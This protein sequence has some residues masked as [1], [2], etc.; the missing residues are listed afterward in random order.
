MALGEKLRKA[1]EERGMS[2][3]DVAASTH[4]L[5]RQIEAIEKEDFSGI[6]APIYGKGFVKLFAECVGL[7]PAPL[8]AEFLEIY[9]GARPPVIARRTIPQT[10]PMRRP[11]ARPVHRATAPAPVA[12]APAAQPPAA[13][14]APVA[15]TPV[16]PP[17]APPPAAPAPV[18]PAPVAPAV[19]APPVAP[20]QAEA[21][22]EEPAA[23]E[24]A[25]S[26]VVDPVVEQEPIAAA[27]HSG[28]A[29]SSLG[30]LF[31]AAASRGQG[32]AEPT[33][34]AAPQVFRPNTPVT[35]PATTPRQP[36]PQPPVRRRVPSG[37]AQQAPAAQ[38]AQQQPRRP[39]APQQP[40]SG[41]QPAVP[42]DEQAPRRRF[43]FSPSKFLANKWVV[44]GLC[45]VIALLVVAGAIVSSRSNAPA[46]PATPPAAQTQEAAPATPATPA[47][48]SAE[49]VP[50]GLNERVVAPPSPYME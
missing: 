1:R 26:P 8:C 12:P 48:E 23:S 25:A 33:A 50:P 46:A 16:A 27:G 39:I 15:S 41:E 44:A 38:P 31:D 30:E 49:L 11:V 24:P 21:A 13:P 36:A 32:A 5:S 43:S 35:K 18:A 37:P 17:A 42:S 28:F 47:A 10:S 7:D 2:V 19:V 34:P 9:N 40:A 4:L 20:V 29:A 6:V 45:A 3:Q 14:A 22:P